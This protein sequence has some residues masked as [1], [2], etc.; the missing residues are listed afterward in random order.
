LCR[1][2]SGANGGIAGGDLRLI[3]KTDR[4]VDVTGIYNIKMATFLLSLL[5]VNQCGNSKSYDQAGIIS[6]PG[7]KAH[8]RGAYC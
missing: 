5:E 7:K 2:I 6:P 8:P 1:Y 3:I 4:V